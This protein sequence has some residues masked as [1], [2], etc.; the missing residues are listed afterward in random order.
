MADTRTCRNCG[1]APAVA[2][3]LKAEDGGVGV[4]T[5]HCDPCWEEALTEFAALHELFDVL[6]VEV[7]PTLADAYIQE[8]IAQ[9]E[10]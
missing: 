9:S 1:T 7:G 4:F 2:H 3:R 10:T 8:L 5:T 6:C